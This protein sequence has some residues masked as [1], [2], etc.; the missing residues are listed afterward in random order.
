MYIDERTAQS[1]SLKPLRI[2]KM[3]VSAIL[4]TNELKSQQVELKIA[5]ETLINRVAKR[6]KPLFIR[7]WDLDT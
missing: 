5:L 2:V 4:G 1:L 7:I 3:S 6:Y